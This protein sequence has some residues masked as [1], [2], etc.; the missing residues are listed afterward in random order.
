MKDQRE[1]VMAGV[2]KALGRATLT[3]KIRAELDARVADPPVHVRPRIGEDLLKRFV[4]QLHAVAATTQRV[5]DVD[6][7]PAAVLS[8]LQDHD[9]GQALVVAPVLRSL[10][11]PEQLEL[12]FGV[13][14]GLD[15]VSVT[16]CI[17][18]VAETGTVVLLSGPE[19]PTTLNFLP[20]DHIVIVNIDQ[21]VAYAEDVWPKL[22]ALPDGLPRTVNLISGPSKTADVEQTLQLG[23]HGPRRLHVLLVG[24]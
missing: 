19:S 9:L 4:T 8:Y 16:P 2:R 7:V 15:S 11:W 22:R 3:P 6:A 18:A 23:A 20:D 1:S 10:P 13:S 24:A 5:A 17:A 21:L 12:R 14:R